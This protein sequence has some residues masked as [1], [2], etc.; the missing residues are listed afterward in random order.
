MYKMILTD[1]DNTLLQSDKTISEKTLY[2]LQE[3]R[4]QGM[5]LTIATARYW[6]GAER[7]IQQLKPDYE[8]T[9]DGTLIH[10]N[11]TCV[12]SC[13]FDPETT[14]EI[15]SEIIK[16]APQSE[17]TVAIGQTVLWNSKHIS[18]SK[19]LYKAQYCDYKA[20]INCEANKI[21]ADLPNEEIAIRIAET[22]GCKL[23]SYRGE[24]WYGFLP[25][26]AGKTEAIKELVN[27]CHIQPEE[28]VAFGD[29]KNDVEMLR[30]CGKG[31]AVANAIDEVRDIADEI[32]Q[33][34]DEDGVAVWLERYLRDCL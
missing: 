20:P 24:K 26:K 15:V 19:N 2:V 34:N 25:K 7:Y 6:I 28:F 18:E 10:S 29:D 23:Q 4:K 3:C 1:L 27:I 22:I 9:T 30:L 8:I 12:Y 32:T 11:E 5:L 33:T 31:I 16:Q 17:I 21:V 14:N 13:S